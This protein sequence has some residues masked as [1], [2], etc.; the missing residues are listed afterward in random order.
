MR[1]TRSTVTFDQ[2]FI[3]NMDIGELPAGKYQIDTDEEEIPASDRTAY[4]RTA[5]YLYVS[6]GGS[7]RMLVIDPHDLESALGRDSQGDA[8]ATG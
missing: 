2:P 1:T 8:G 7:T 3:L 4:R 6:N 5:V